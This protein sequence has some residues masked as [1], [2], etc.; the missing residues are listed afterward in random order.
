MLDLLNQYFLSEYNWLLAVL[1][2]NEAALPQNKF[3]NMPKEEMF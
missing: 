2:E 3:K 1:L